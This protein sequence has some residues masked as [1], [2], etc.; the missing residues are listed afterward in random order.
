MKLATFSI[1]VSVSVSTFSI[2]L[3]HGH[4]LTNMLLKTS[5]LYYLLQCGRAWTK[6]QCNICGSKI[7]GMS[8]ILEPGNEQDTE[9]VYNW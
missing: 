2:A 6:S 7:G 3:V 5:F 4:A 1:S 9:Y 8:C